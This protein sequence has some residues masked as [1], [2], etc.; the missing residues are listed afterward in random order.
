[1][2]WSRRAD[3]GG[4]GTTRAMH[5]HRPHNRNVTKLKQLSNY[6]S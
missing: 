2:A 6:V 3:L 1:M 5:S 4:E